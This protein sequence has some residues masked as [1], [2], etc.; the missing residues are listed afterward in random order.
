MIV[1]NYYQ[2][3]T[4]MIVILFILGDQ[5]TV[6]IIIPPMKFLHINIQVFSSSKGFSLI[7]PTFL[8]SFLLITM[9][10]RTLGITAAAI[11]AAAGVE[12]KYTTSGP[13]VFYYWGQVS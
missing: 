13:N 8:P 4:I 7:Q 11:L 3:V 5:S 2:R 10:L 12:A 6:N 1:V 9:L